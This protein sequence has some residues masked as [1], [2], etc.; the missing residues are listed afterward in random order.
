MD[1]EKAKI[2]IEALERSKHDQRERLKLAAEAKLQLEKKD[3][4]IM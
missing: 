3:N 4:K 2:T 1:F